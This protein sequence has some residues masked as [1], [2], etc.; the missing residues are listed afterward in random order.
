MQINQRGPNDSPLPEGEIVL[1]LYTTMPSDGK[2]QPNMFEFSSDEKAEEYKRISVWASSLTT[3]QQ[4]RSFMDPSKEYE[5]V[6]YLNVS[7]VRQLVFEDEHPPLDVRWH[8]M[9][10]TGPGAEGHSAVCNLD[11]G[12]DRTQ[13]K[14]RRTR[15]ADIAGLIPYQEE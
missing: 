1:R 9:D 7:R 10:F 12:D 11:K 15:L 5:A 14:V 13:R 3:P 4:A 2:A 8:Y 6:I